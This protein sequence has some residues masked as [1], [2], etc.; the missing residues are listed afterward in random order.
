[1]VSGAVSWQTESLDTRDWLPGVSRANHTLTCRR[2]V[3][4]VTLSLPICV[5]WW[6]VLE[7]LN[8][9]QWNIISVN[10]H[11]A[12]CSIPT[13]QKIVPVRGLQLVDPF[14]RSGLQL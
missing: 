7:E 6:A 8:G 2:V 12:I 13:S 3:K 4:A 14:A 1:M 11:N 9:Y 5:F 10:V